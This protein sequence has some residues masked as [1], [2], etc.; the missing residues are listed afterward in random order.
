TRP[1]RPCAGSDR[2]AHFPGTPTRRPCC[3][4][5]RAVRLHLAVRGRGKQPWAVLLGR[6]TTRSARPRDAVDEIGDRYATVLHSGERL[7]LAPWHGTCGAPLRART[8]HRDRG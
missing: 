6:D 5:T 1:Q 3:R 4:W 8:R 2:L 7:C